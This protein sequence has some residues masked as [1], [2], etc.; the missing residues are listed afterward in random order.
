MKKDIQV[1]KRELKYTNV[2]GDIKDN[3]GNIVAVMKKRTIE[4]SSDEFISSLVAT[5]A[6]KKCILSTLSSSKVLFDI[7]DTRTDSVVARMDKQRNLYDLEGYYIGTLGNAN[8]LHVY[9]HILTVLT[10]IAIL[11]AAITLKESTTKKIDSE[12]VISEADGTVVTDV[13]NILGAEQKDKILY[14]GKNY[15]YLFNVI[16]TNDVPVSFVIEF[17]DINLAEIPMRYRLSTFDGFIVGSEYTWVEMDDLEFEPIV[18]PAQSEAT[19]A[20]HWKW[21]TLSD[22]FDTVIGNTDGAEYV[23]NVAYTST[24]YDENS[25]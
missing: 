20:L 3:D 21:Q 19:F 4:T 6:T 24:I 16:N 22:D 18:I 9:L 15:V 7:I 8:Y 17:D 25:K 11:L 5:D 10:I 14:P 2:F 23:I 1:F 12:I 13:W